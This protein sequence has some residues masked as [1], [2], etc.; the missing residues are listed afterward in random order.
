MLGGIEM[1][2][3]FAEFVSVED[4]DGTMATTLSF[5][6]RQESRRVSNGARPDRAVERANMPGPR[7][8]Y[9]GLIE[10]S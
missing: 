1:Q 5:L 7:P 6:W 3:G 4:S 10:A 9:P 2:R 8:H